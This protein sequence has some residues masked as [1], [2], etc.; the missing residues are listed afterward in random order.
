MSFQR[1]PQV[2]VCFSHLR[3]KFVFQRPQHILTRAS[4][5]FPV[6]FIE[7]PILESGTEPHLKIE[8]I[9]RTLRVVTPVIPEG[10]DHQPLLDELYKE[11]SGSEVIAWF[12]TPMAIERA[13]TLNADVIVYDCMDELSAFKYAPP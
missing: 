4:R 1:V 8:N 2:L 5:H 9:S 12:Y 3:W 10:Y 7:D 11:F 13:A 6:V